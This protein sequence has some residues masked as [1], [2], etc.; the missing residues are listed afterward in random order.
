M[1]FSLEVAR[2]M[3]LELD[4]LRVAGRAP[5]DDTLTERVNGRL[6]AVQAEVAKGRTFLELAPTAA[7][8]ETLRT[9]EAYDLQALS[10]A[11]R[12]L[13]G[14]GA[15]LREQGN[16]SEPQPPS[17]PQPQPNVGAQPQSASPPPAGRSPTTKLQIGAETPT[18]RTP[19][20]KL[21]GARAPQDEVAIRG[22]A[23]R[24]AVRELPG[25]TRQTGKLD[26]WVAGN[27]APRRNTGS[28][29]PQSAAGRQFGDRSS[30]GG[31]KAFEAA[32]RLATEVLGYVSPRLALVQ[33]AMIATGLPGPRHPWPQVQSAFDPPAKLAEGI[34]PPLRPWLPHLAKLFYTEMPI[35]RDAL[36]ALQQWSQ[37]RQMAQEAEKVA[38][39]LARV[40]E[41]AHG[42]V[43]A[44]FNSGQLRGAA[45]ALS[46]LHARFKGVAHLSVLFP[47]PNA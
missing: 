28:L 18:V 9:L 34:Q 1:A 47:P 23:P 7:T 14:L 32:R 3:R 46:H 31:A 17:Q 24:P 21:P 22:I 16:P 5:W 45:Y 11:T 25:G 33:A 30:V 10:A 27:T 26:H 44:G 8:L 41:Q 15:S 6:A 29:A 36:L 43:L 37:A 2:A 13:Q 40:P 38:G 42:Q 12:G 4:G 19:T 35:A 20:G 39:T